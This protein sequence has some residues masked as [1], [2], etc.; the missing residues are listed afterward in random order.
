[1]KGDSEAVVGRDV[2]C[3]WRSVLGAWAVA[4]CLGAGLLL[5]PTDR[6]PS[7]GFDPGVVHGLAF[8]AGGSAD[9]ID[10]SG[11]RLMLAEAVEP[12]IRQREPAEVAG[13]NPAP[14]VAPCRAGQLLHAAA[15]SVRRIDAFGWMRRI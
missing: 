11:D 14:E 10:E 9:D 5:L 2:P 15:R 7:P 6:S 1:M 12:P 13:A 8:N 4:A 3:N